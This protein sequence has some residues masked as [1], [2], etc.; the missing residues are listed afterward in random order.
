MADKSFLHW[1][2]FEDFHRALSAEIECWCAAN[3]P[4]DHA[5]VDSACRRL[6]KALEALGKAGFL[7]HTGA[8]QGR[9]LDVRSLCL[10]RETLARHDEL[11]DFA[12]AMQG[13]GMGAVSLFGIDE[14][15]AWLEQTRTGEAISAFALTEPQSGSDVANIQT[16]AVEEGDDY[17]IDGEK[18]EPVRSTSMELR[19]PDHQRRNG[20]EYI[21]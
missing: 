2:F 11:A 3:L 8:G 14:Q 9:A 12:F 13:L 17:I 16:M 10:I 5:D 15:R 4:F 20:D 18:N 1:P 6:V 7:H 19:S 21:E